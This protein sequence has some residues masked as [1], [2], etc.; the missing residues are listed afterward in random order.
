VAKAF[1]TVW[2]D[3]LLY[4]L[5]VLNFPSYFAKP[6]LLTCMAGSLKHPS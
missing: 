4:K 3:D 5:M 1:D 2:V 6:S